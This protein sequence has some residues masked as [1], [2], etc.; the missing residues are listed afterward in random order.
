[1]SFP[2]PFEL[3]NAPRSF[4]KSDEP[5]VNLQPTVQFPLKSGV[6]QVQ[7]VGRLKDP[8]EIIPC[9]SSVDTLTV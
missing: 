1:M 8:W 2:S 9:W 7:A 3:L 5:N 6:A 4:G